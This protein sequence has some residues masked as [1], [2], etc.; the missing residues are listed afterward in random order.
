M[1]KVIDLCGN[2][3]DAYG[4]FLDSEGDIQFILCD[5][6]G[7]FYKTNTIKGSYR[8]YEPEVE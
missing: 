8:L 7:E 1:F 4:T 6:D 3:H 2:I 5:A